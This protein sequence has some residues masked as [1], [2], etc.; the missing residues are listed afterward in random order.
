MHPP[1]AGRAR[2]PGPC[3]NCRG[4]RLSG[5]V[6]VLAECRQGASIIQNRVLRNIPQ[7]R[8]EQDR[9]DS[10]YRLGKLIFGDL[11]GGKLTPDQLVPGLGLKDFR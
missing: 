6:V 2:S 11:N 9:V 5:G 10:R 1:S 8:I 4:I 3:H 7:L